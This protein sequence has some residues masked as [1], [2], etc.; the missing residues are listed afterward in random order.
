MVCPAQ[1]MQTSCAVRTLQPNNAQ[2]CVC[3]LW[4]W[5]L[6]TLKPGFCVCEGTNENQVYESYVYW[7]V[8]HL[9]A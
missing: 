3:N 4:L 1:W 9:D 6:H 2:E 5:F 7:T 8:H